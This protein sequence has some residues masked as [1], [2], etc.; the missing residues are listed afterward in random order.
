[1]LVQCKTRGRSQD[2]NSFLEVTRRKGNPGLCI[3]ALEEG[4]SSV[5]LFNSA[6]KNREMW[7]DV[8]QSW[9]KENHL[10][11]WMPPH[12]KTSFVAQLIGKRETKDSGLM[13]WIGFLFLLPSSSLSP[14]FFF[15]KHFS[16]PG[17]VSPL[18]PELCFP[19]FINHAA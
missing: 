2:P 7:L 5:P 15:H 18:S 1:M 13:D 14:L 10:S 16:P 19:G 17:N 6:K 11:Q 8:R 3:H 12:Q 9:V 4:S